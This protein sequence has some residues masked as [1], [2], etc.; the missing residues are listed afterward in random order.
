MRQAVQKMSQF[1]NRRNKAAAR[2]L[3]FAWHL[4]DFSVQKKKALII[5][6]SLVFYEM[7]RR[8]IAKLVK[9]F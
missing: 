3:N 7:A 1:P 2:D 4:F 9:D 8:N 6:P 5:S